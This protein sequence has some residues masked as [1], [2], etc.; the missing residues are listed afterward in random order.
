MKSFRILFTVLMLAAGWSCGGAQPDPAPS[1]NP[2]PVPEPEPEKVEGA[3]G[4]ITSADK[5]CLF[6]E[7]DISFGKAA[8]MSPYLVNLDP[9]VKYQTID[10][11]GAAMTWAS[12]YNLL[13][14]DP[15]D[16]AALLK[17]LFDPET[18]LG[19]GLIRVSIGASDFNYEEYT[20]CDKS[21]IENFAVDSRDRSTVFPILK[22]IY[23]IN[24][25]INIIASP[26]SVPKWM[27]MKVN[28]TGTYDSWTSGRLNPDY[29]EAYAEYLVRW[30]EVMEEEGFRIEAITLQNEPLNHGNSMS[31][32]MPWEDQRDFIK[33]AMGKALAEAQ[34]DTKILVFDHNYNYDNNSGQEQY[35]LHIYND[36]E[37]SKY[38]AGSAWHNYGGSVTEL[39]KIHEAA[40]DKEIYFTEASIGTWNYDFASC[41]VNDFKSIFLQTLEYY[42]KGVTLWNFVLDDK[43]GPYSPQSGSCKTCYGVV[44]VSS[45][46]YKLTDRK[47]HY[48][49]IA[50]ASVAARPGAVR[51]GTSGYTANGITYQA[52]SNPDGGYGVMILNETSSEQQ[53]VFADS[54]HSVKISVPGKSIASLRW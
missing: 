11:F 4:W 50:H 29:Y 30:I 52:F 22:E 32:Y 15:E 49:N 3:K 39:K 53:L 54:E 27:K 25:D 20:W 24:P 1:P 47:T 31:T 36:S 33:K 16:R 8:S 44:E 41:L 38:V 23:A 40:P 35:P 18:G 26:W 28:G 42:N 7:S 9:S 14:M 51:I 43:K 13:K 34:L 37:A 17:D 46:D 45:S 5:T 12:C 19:I 2:D 21:G 10:G 6:K 48:Y